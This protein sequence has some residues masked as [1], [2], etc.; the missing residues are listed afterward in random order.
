MPHAAISVM[1]GIAGCLQLAWL[2]LGTFELTTGKTLPKET[3]RR[4]VIGTALFGALLPALLWWDASHGEVVYQLRV[5]SRRVLV[6]LAALVAARAISRAP[7]IARAIGRRTVTLAFF[8]IAAHQVHFLALST[9]R[10]I[11]ILN[12]LWLATLGFVDV[13]LYVAL[14]MGLVIWLLEEERQATIRRGKIEQ[15]AYH[16]PL[17]GLPNR[18][19]FLNQLA[20]ALHPARR[21]ASSRCSSSTSI[22]SR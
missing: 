18:Q 2:L 9:D 19:L 7:R 11:R 16:D 13:M 14:A 5:T 8:G 12:P 22:A 20:I 3:V 15:I 6:A 4:I 10:D 17:T 21:A 1:S